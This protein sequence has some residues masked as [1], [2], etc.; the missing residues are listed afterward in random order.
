MRCTECNSF[1]A[2]DGRPCRACV[3]WEAH[4]RQGHRCRNCGTAVADG[5]TRCASC[6]A[7]RRAPDHDRVRRR[8]DS[9]FPAPA[10]TELLERL[11][12]G[13]RLTE[14]CQ[15]LKVAVQ[16]VHRWAAYEPAWS[17][18]L[19]Q[20]LTDGRDPTLDHGTEAAYR[21]GRCRCP[22]CRVAKA[23]RRA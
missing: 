5:Q 7:R 11:A 9:R 3:Y 1:R 6:R 20:A 4:T 19:D 12:A 8:A 15:D 14:V 21:R 2:A 13:G 17:S 18:A 22:E 23:I 16:Q 10:R